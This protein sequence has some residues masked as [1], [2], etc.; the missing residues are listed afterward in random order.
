M[1]RFFLS[2]LGE[3]YLGH[4]GFDGIAVPVAQDGLD[5]EARLGLEDE[6]AVGLTIVFHPLVDAVEVVLLAGVEGL[7]QVVGDGDSGGVDIVSVGFVEGLPLG[8]SLHRILRLYDG[9]NY[10]PFVKIEP[11]INPDL[12]PI[13]EGKLIMRSRLLFI[14]V[15]YFIHFIP[16]F[17]PSFYL[18]Y[19]LL[20]CLY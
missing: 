11:S 20:I 12:E 18:S 15:L 2:G 17:Y 1:A 13:Q 8:F 9:K 10:I 3:Q 6:W 14:Y 5:A 4:I 16:I 7:L 19:F